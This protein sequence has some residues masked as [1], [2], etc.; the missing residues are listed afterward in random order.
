MGR[1]A[2]QPL[3]RNLK[4]LSSLVESSNLEKYSCTQS[5]AKTRE[6]KRYRWYC[7]AE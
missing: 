5:E 2:R 1:A 6:P 4:P 7:N 3:F